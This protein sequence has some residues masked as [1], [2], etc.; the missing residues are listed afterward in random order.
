MGK[1]FDTYFT[2]GDF[3]DQYLERIL[4]GLNS[5]LPSFATLPPYFTEGME[6]V[7]ILERM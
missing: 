6:N 5:S 7:Y 1:I 2:F 4:V 3:G